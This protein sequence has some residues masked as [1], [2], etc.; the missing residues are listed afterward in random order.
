MTAFFSWMIYLTNI[1]SMI[2]TIVF[3]VGTITNNTRIS[4]KETFTSCNNQIKICKIA[5]LVFVV[6][7]W[8]I[9]SGMT[10]EEC[11]EGYSKLSSICSV[12][13]CIWIVFFIINIIVSIILALSKKGRDS[14]A[15]LGKMRKSNIVMGVLFLVVAFLLKVK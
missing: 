6:L 1:I 2:A 3:F 8:F 9:V 12:F 13:G 7:Y 15:I 11:L 4:G 10:K 5:S 14:T